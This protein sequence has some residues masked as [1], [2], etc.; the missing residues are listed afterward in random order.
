MVEDGATYVHQTKVF[1]YNPGKFIFKT[2]LFYKLI[3]RGIYGY[4]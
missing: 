2:L 1:H 3:E 4:A